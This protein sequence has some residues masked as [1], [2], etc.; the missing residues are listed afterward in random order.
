MLTFAGEPLLFPDADVLS[1]FERYQDLSDLRIFS[2]HHSRV[3][4]RQACRSRF[5][6][7]KG[8]GLPVWNWPDPPAP[9]LNTVYWPTGATRWA[10]GLFLVTRAT[11]DRLFARLHS[12]NGNAAGTLSMGDDLDGG[13]LS[14]YSMDMYML[15]PR[16]VSSMATDDDLWILPLV[17]ERYFWQ[18]RSVEDL[19]VTTATTWATLFGTLGTRLGRTVAVTPSIA[20]AYLKPDPTE[21]SRRYDNAALLLDAA[22]ASV[23]RRVVRRVTGVVTLESPAVSQAKLLA[24]LKRSYELLA[25]GDYGALG[26]DLP[27]SV[28]VAYQKIKQHLLRKNGQVLVQT[29]A[30]PSGT[31]VQVGDASLTIQ[32][33]AYA[34]YNTADALQNEAT[35]QAI[36]D[37]LASDFY[38]WNSTRY[39]YTFREIQPWDLCGFDDHVLWTFG[40]PI[41]GELTGNVNAE[42]LE[43][44]E[45]AAVTIRRGVDRL[46]QTRVQSLPVNCWPEL[47]AC[48]DGD[49]I[50]FEPRLMAIAD[51]DIAAGAEGTVSLYSDFSTD[52][53]KNVTAR[54]I[55]G[56]IWMATKRGWVEGTGDAVW[57]GSP[58]E[59]A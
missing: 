12:S 44:Q 54:N 34:D 28:A 2:P 57:L 52:T 3:S 1:F 27:S 59:C 48:A 29:S 19:E 20:A 6:Q 46:A 37:Q 50:V 15:N 10:Y 43:E 41:A 4:G 5:E 47:N 16:P 22:A 17:D 39:D 24:N 7:D 11:R 33:A 35:L 14:P 45:S 25:G 49:K 30:A 38:S 9:R 31:P 55:S 23:G 51:G 42:A 36:T 40:R 56:I 21:F 58:N 32:C 53:T 18:Y 8:L 26:G 13:G